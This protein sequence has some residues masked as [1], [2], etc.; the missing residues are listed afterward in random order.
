VLTCRQAI[1]RLTDVETGDLAAPERRAT[2]RHLAA[3]D[4]CLAYWRSYR[5]TVA[6]ERRA[7][8]GEQAASDLV[9]SEDLVRRILAAARNAPAFLAS[10]RYAIHVLSG[11]AAAP[12]IAFWL[13]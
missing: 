3:C 5:T 7:Y 2:K 11:I 12:L 9:A 6:L 8:D 1:S 4:G 13:R 10:A